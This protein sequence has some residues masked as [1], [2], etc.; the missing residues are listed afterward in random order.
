MADSFIFVQQNKNSLALAQQTQFTELE[1]NYAK[2]FH[3]ARSYVYSCGF[4]SLTNYLFDVQAFCWLDDLK[5]ANEK[6]LSSLKPNK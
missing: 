3:I 6:I 4:L 1:Q 5:I 2:Q